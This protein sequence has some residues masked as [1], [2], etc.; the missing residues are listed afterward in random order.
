MPARLRWAYHRDTYVRPE[1][2]GPTEIIINVVG[3]HL[4]AAP[5]GRKP[6]WLSRLLDCGWEHQAVTRLGR[7]GARW[8]T[9]V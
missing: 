3:A 7:G 2:S 9:S 4:V 6:R 8:T 1:R 5:P